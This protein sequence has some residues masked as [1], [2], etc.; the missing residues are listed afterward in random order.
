MK[1]PCTAD[2]FTLQEHVHIIRGDC[3]FRQSNV[4]Y[5][6]GTADTFFPLSNAAREEQRNL[7]A[8]FVLRQL[9]L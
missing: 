8:G 2:N 5:G 7:E 9:R 4:Q 1:K 6:G 3:L